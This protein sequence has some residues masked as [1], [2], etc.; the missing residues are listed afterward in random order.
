[1]METGRDLTVTA[2]G[3]PVT[4][5]RHARLT[6]RDALGLYPMPVTLRL[7]NLAEE[8]FLAL[9]AAKE[10]SVLHGNSLLAGGTVSDVY[11]RRTSEG[12]VTETVFA[13]GLPLWEA[14]IS[15]SVE[16]GVSVSDTARRIL[17]ASG[18]GIRLLSFPGR[19][20]VRRRSQAFYGRAA[21][22][23]EEALAAVSARG[24]LAGS[25]L[26]VVPAEGMPVSLFLSSTDLVEEPAFTG[27]GLMLLRTKMAGWPLGAGIEVK[28]KDGSAEGLV[29]ERFI[30]AD[31]MEG[32]WRCEL[33]AERTP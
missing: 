26:G 12:T 4:G 20:P 3:R 23:A 14:P 2:D 24:Y 5:F 31:N 6:G 22:C 11:R 25:G 18:T 17:E 19:D 33:L 21:E 8:D 28:W 32:N 15:L 27:G 30:D 13:A 7:W 1:M 10:V 16:A 29:L 9:A